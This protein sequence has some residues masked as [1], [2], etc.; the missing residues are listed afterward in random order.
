M[1]KPKPA[2]N[3]PNTAF[4]ITILEALTKGKSST[5]AIDHDQA[6]KIHEAATVSA[7]LDDLLKAAFRKEEQHREKIAKRRAKSNQA[8]PKK[9]KP[10][11]LE[12]LRNQVASLSR[13][14]DGL[15]KT[16]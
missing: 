6:R 1:E 5:S 8:K 7:H 14:K 4:G 11:E 13:L 12:N 2:L 9:P 10:T 16:S 3:K 15:K